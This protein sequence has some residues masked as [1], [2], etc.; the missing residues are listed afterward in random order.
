[1]WELFLRHS[2]SCNFCSDN[3]YNVILFHSEQLDNEIN[4]QSRQHEENGGFAGVHGATE[5]RHIQNA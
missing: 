1:M 4:G 5:F 2:G 3:Y